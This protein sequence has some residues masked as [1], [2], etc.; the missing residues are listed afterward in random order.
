MTSVWV[1]SVGSVTSL[2]GA[3]V[4]VHNTT[5][6]HVYITLVSV[7]VRQQYMGRE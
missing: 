1:M 5:L 6:Y 2:R 7:N 3:P 4:S